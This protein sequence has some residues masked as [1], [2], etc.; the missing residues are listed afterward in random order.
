ME[1]D[2]EKETKLKKEEEEKRN[3]QTETNQMGK[4]V[5]ILLKRSV[6]IH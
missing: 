4:K 3:N 2:S 1:K 5:Y 6:D